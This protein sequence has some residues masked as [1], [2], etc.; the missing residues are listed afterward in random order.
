MLRGVEIINSSPLRGAPADDPFVP[1]VGLGQRLGQDEAECNSAIPGTPSCLCGRARTLPTNYSIIWTQY[2]PHSTKQFGVAAQ[3][4]HPVT[5]QAVPCR[6]QSIPKIYTS[7]V[8]QRQ[9]MNNI[10]KKL[11]NRSHC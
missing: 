2:R 10:L 7:I 11:K 4:A 9:T 1:I 5:T 8:I 3:S 6:R